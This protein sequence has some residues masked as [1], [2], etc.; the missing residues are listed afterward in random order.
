MAGVSS[1]VRVTPVFEFKISALRLEGA[2]VG[3]VVHGDA[4]AALAG[5]IKLSGRKLLHNGLAGF[6]LRCACLVSAQR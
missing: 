4:V 5:A 3:L 6:L 1:D 2:C